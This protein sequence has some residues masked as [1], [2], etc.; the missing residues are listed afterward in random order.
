MDDTATINGRD[1]TPTD[2]VSSRAPN[3]QNTR[4]HCGFF[5]TGLLSSNRRHYSGACYEIWE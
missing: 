3:I 5:Q 4:T 2:P 1:M